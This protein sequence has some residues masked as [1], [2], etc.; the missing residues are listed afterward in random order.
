MLS[1]SRILLISLFGL[2]AV[3][4]PQQAQ[5]VNCAIEIMKNC[6]PK[7]DE[8]SFK[9]AVCLNNPEYAP[10]VTVIEG[11]VNAAM[12]GQDVIDKDFTANIELRVLSAAKSKS[13]PWKDQPWADWILKKRAGKYIEAKTGSIQKLETAQAAAMQAEAEKE[14]AEKE[15]AESIAFQKEMKEMEFKQTK[16][17]AESQY[18]HETELAERQ[19]QQQ[20][21]IAQQD[22]DLQLQINREQ[23]GFQAQQADQQIAFAREQGK[24]NRDLEEKKFT[25]KLIGG[26][27]ESVITGFASFGSSWMKYDNIGGDGSEKETNSNSSWNFYKTEKEAR[28]NMKKEGSR[29]KETDDGWLVKDSYLY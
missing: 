29:I 28:E 5:A 19:A 1:S 15:H 22:R 18:K 9:C 3:V 10:S 7:N 26:I 25:Y 16:E 20:L 8:T 13:Y 14:A 27:S 2:G 21:T 4:I 17:L 23:L 11:L 6:M 24:A 12:E